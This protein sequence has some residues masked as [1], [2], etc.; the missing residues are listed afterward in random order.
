[1]IEK[2]FMV[3]YFI[4]NHQLV[5]LNKIISSKNFTKLNTATYEF[6][7]IYFFCFINRALPSVKEN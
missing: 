6:H 2:Y 4:R 5:A 3:F 1:M 7:E